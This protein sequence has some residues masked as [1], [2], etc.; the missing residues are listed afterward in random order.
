MPISIKDDPQMM[1]EIILDHYQNPRN[2]KK[3][4]DPSYREVHMASSSCIDDIY[5]QLKEEN[6]IVVDCLWHGKGCAISTASTSIMT[7]LVKGQSVERAKY[8]MGE[9]QKMMNGENFD[10]EALGEGLAFINTNRQPSR[11]TCATIGWRGLDELFGED[12]KE[13]EGHKDGKGK[14]N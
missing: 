5:I 10:E 6:G 2:Y 11:I 8:L 13:C 3:T 9:F 7:D 14:G 1:R 12:E 4:D